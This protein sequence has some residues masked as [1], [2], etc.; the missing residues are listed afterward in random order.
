MGAAAPIMSLASV[1]LSAAGSYEK[2]VGQQAAD[3]MRAAQLEEQAQY[4]RMAADET[5]ANLLDKL[6]LTLGNIDA[7]RA[8]S[9]TDP[10]SPTGAVIRDRTEML[11]DQERQ[12]RVGNINAQ[13]SEDQASAAYMRSAGSFAMMQ[14][15]IGAG[16]SLFGGL[17]KT[18]WSSFGVG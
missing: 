1:G 17:G 16:A 15:E 8:A 11:G 10:S 9:H 4:G 18:N 5:N 2:G 3:N 13:V 12:T 14:G 7:V 6:N